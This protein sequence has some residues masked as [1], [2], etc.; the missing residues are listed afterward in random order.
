MCILALF[1]VGLSLSA[2]PLTIVT[3]DAWDG[4]KDKGVFTLRAFEAEEERAFRM[5]IMKAGLKNIDAQ[6]VMLTGLNGLPDAAEALS[7]ELN[8]QGLYGVNRG[9]FRIG[10][11][12]FPW[13]LR[14]GSVLLARE[15]LEFQPIETR[16]F[17]GL[18]IKN[19]VAVGS[20]PAPQV[21]AG[22]LTAY[23]REVYVFTVHWPGV[24]GNPGEE[25]ESLTEEYL[26][27]G[28]D[29]DDYVKAVGRT[30]DI[31]EDRLDLVYSTLGF[32]NNLAG[33]AP[34]ILAGSLNVPPDSKE[35]DILR[36]AGFKDAWQAGVGPGYTLDGERNLN[37]QRFFEDEY[38]GRRERFDYILYRGDGIDIMSAE[39]VFDEPT[40][41]VHPS[42]RFGVYAK[43]EVTPAS[44]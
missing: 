9:G 4:L 25:L 43:L 18:F 37:L 36:R 14:K 17:S 32:V 34:V 10:V 40:F 38:A 19:T 11:V 13:N 44:E 31:N 30:V 28:M 23:G 26:S 20:K 7:S 27:G 1:L 29:G 8:Y 24:S 3:L 16:R 22:K 2:E 33:D 21:L 15:A 42:D 12:G 39:T 5:D 41:G 6:V 35:M